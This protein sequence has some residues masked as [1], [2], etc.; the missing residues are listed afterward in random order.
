MANVTI[1]SGYVDMTGFLSLYTTSNV[2]EFSPITIT[3]SRAGPP[4]YWQP[5]VGS[6]NW[7]GT[8]PSFSTTSGSAGQPDG[9]RQQQHRHVRRHGLGH[10]RRQHG[11]HWGRPD[12]VAATSIIVSNI[13]GAYN[14]TGNGSVTADAVY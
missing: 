12:G 14:F 7:D 5:A 11:K 1:P 9:R 6:N 2:P 8:T 10:Q 3:P 4:L 13:G